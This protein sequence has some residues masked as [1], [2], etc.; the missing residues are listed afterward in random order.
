M[1]VPLTVPS[2]DAN[3]VGV[4]FTSTSRPW[5]EVLAAPNKSWPVPVAAW[6]LIVP[7]TSVPVKV[8]GVLVAEARPV[9]PAPDAVEVTVKDEAEP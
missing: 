6:P 5:A 3:W 8:W 4:A 9:V 1:M 2:S 7:W